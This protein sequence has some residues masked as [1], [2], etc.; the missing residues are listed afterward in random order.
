[1]GKKAPRKLDDHDPYLVLKP[2]QFAIL[3]CHERFSLPR[4][5]MGFITLR[6]RYKMQGLV[7]VSGF[8][9]DPTFR[10]KLV[11][12]VQNVG[13]TEIR[14]KYKQ[15]FTIFFATVD[16]NTNT[17]KEATPRVGITLEDIAQLGGSTI[18]HFGKLKEEMDQ[19]RRTVFVYAPIVSLQLLLPSSSLFE[20][21]NCDYS[22]CLPINQLKTR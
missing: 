21:V 13:A 22:E 16:K 12:A 4:H 2:G 5:I 6:N 8:H 20:K 14:L 10:E 3:T 11:F 7:N 18:T 1:M 19:L 17:T 9:V 15:T